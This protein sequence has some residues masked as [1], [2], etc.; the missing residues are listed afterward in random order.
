MSLFDQ[1]RLDNRTFKLDI[2]RMRRGWYADKY[3]TNIQ[4]IL[5]KL[6]DEG[7]TYGGNQHCLPQASA[8]RVL[9]VVT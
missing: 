8:L 2:E 3:F 7:Y 4:T 5:A 6:S 9:P 1:N